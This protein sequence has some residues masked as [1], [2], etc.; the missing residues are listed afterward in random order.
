[1]VQS[2]HVAANKLN[3]KMG[4]GKHCFSKDLLKYILCYR[5]PVC[6]LFDRKLTFG[7]NISCKVAYFARNIIKKSPADK[8]VSI[9]WGVNCQVTA[10][11]GHLLLVVDRLAFCN[12]HQT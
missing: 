6:I 9:G 11:I 2:G 8:L 10:V 3:S 12:W 5:K 1:M 4:R 7:F